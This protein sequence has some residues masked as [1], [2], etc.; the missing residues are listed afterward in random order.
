[1][2]NTPLW[3]NPRDEGEVP[4]FLGDLLLWAFQD[5]V[6]TKNGGRQIVL[7]LST[8]SEHPLY[9]RKGATWTPCDWSGGCRSI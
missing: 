2:G 1:M 6:T 3:R 9:S 7:Q 8:A 5:V 4:D